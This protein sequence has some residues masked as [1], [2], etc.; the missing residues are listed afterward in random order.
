MNLERR[1]KRSLPAYGITIVRRKRD[2][3]ALHIV[4]LLGEKKY[5]NSMKRENNL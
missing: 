5:S 2:T 1:R 3:V 4:S